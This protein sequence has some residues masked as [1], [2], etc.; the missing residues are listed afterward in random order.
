MNRIHFF[1]AGA[2]DEANGSRIARTL[3][4]YDELDYYVDSTVLYSPSSPIDRN[5]T[6]GVA[7]PEASATLLQ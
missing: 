5:G 6:E 3:L 2:N 7:T 4:K 1:L